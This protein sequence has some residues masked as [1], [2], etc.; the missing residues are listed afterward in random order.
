MG[1]VDFGSVTKLGGLLLYKVCRRL[2]G[3][4]YFITKHHAYRFAHIAWI[5]PK[6]AEHV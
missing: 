5:F 6:R 4:S 2:Y 3:F 1:T